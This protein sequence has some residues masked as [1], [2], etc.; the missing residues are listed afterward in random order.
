MY[1]F[2]EINDKN[3]RE[4]KFFLIENFNRPRIFWEK[5]ILNFINYKSF[6][7]QK[8]FGYCYYFNDKIIASIFLIFDT[9]NQ[10]YSLS[11]MYVDEQHRS[12]TISFVNKVFSNLKNECILDFTA[13]DKAKKLFNYFGL[14]EIH[15]SVYIKVPTKF[16]KNKFFKVTEDES[17]KI[18]KDKNIFYADNMRVISESNSDQN[19]YFIYKDISITKSNMLRK[20]SLLI[21]ADKVDSNIINDLSIY[22][23]MNGK[24]HI[25]F[26]KDQNFKIKLSR[27][28]VL[29]KQLSPSFHGNS[30]LSIF[31]F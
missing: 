16:P 12:K 5:S 28:S 10:A 19:S 4:I 15:E 7:N 8:N 30:E 22:C 2:S 11:S 1:R 18:C 29:S 13:T 14:R 20:I 26:I 21:Y 9:F 6:S 31:D 24:I 23:W 3:L 25:D 17:L 27:F